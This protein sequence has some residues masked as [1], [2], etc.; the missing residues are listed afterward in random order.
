[1][2]A[3]IVI[4]VLLFSTC[5]LL[6]GCGDMFGNA[7]EEHISGKYYLV[8]GDGREQMGLCTTDEFR[9]Y[10]G[11]IVPTVFAIGYDKD[12]IIVKQHPRHF[13]GHD[14]MN[15]QVTSY[16]IVALK[17]QRGKSDTDIV[18]GPMTKE[19]FHAKRKELGVPEDLQFTRVFKDL[20]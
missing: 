10:L 7:Y 11:V 2:I 3:K 18:Y 12:F 13:D 17:E 6:I 19:K 4:Y 5:T 20:E 8:A 9:G 16:Y 1:M 15:R 14:V